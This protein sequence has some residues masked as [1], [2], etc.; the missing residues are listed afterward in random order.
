MRENWTDDRLDYLNRRVDDGFMQVDARFK[1]VDERF[2]QAEKR[3]D[4]R[5][6]DVNRRMSRLESQFDQLNQN[7]AAFSSTI[8][9]LI[10]AM[11]G[12][13]FVGFL[14]VLATTL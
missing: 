9:Q 12:T 10:F 5:F 3:I 1:H 4:E 8:V 7:F 14:T 11:I 13:M 6:D 2:D